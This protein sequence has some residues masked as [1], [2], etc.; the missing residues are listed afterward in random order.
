MRM[1]NRVSPGNIEIRQPPVYL[2][3]IQTIIESLLH[4][5]PT[6]GFYFFTSI[7]R[8]DIAM[9][10]SLVTSIR[11]MPL[12][13]KILFHM[14]TLPPLLYGTHFSEY[15]LYC[16]LENTPQVSFLFLGRISDEVPVKDYL[17]PAPQAVPHA[18]VAFSSSLL[19]HPNKFAS[20][21]FLTSICF[22]EL[23][24]ARKMIV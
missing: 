5:L 21:I 12:K 10:A 9:L 22:V 18:A 20:A 16:P 7:L 19:L 23:F 8:K 24:P 3:E 15:I 1:K 14:F 4:L 11:N 13:C 6:H 17:S 2:T